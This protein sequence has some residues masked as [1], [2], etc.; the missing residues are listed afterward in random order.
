VAANAAGNC[1]DL[2]TL[3]SSPAAGAAGGAAPT[4]S[5]DTS[6]TI[7]AMPFGYPGNANPCISSPAT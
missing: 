6:A 4:G 1:V 5:T 3:G 7:G 2:W